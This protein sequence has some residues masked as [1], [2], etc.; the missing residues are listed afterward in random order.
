MRESD[1]MALRAAH[2]EAI[3]S[4]FTA[5]YSNYI[6]TCASRA[7]GKHVTKNDDEWSIAL[8]A[9]CESVK[10]YSPD[11]GE[12]IPFAGMVIQRRVTDLMRSRRK[13]SNELP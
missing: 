5:E 2:D 10:A 3:L 8:A 11:K 6:L 13:F 1:E 12:F 4:S 7:S 9:F